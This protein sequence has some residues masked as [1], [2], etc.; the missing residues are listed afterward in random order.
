MSRKSALIQPLVWLGTYST[1]Y[2]VAPWLSWRRM[3]FRGDRLSRGSLVR[4]VTDWPTSTKAGLLK[5]VPGPDRI[6]TRDPCNWPRIEAVQELRSWA[7]APGVSRGR[8][9]SRGAIVLIAPIKIFLN[10]INLLRLIFLTSKINYGWQ[11]SYFRKSDPASGV[12]KAE[13]SSGYSENL[14]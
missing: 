9:V 11:L 3:G 4:R 14:L 12:T 13:S 6:F 5:S 10:F 1:R 7:M 2:Q 8:R